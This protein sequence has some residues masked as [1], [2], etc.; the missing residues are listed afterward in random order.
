MNSVHPFLE[1]GSYVPEIDNDLTNLYHY[2][3]DKQ[4]KQKITVADLKDL[5]LEKMNKETIVT[6]FNQMI[7]STKDQFGYT[8]HKKENS[9]YEV[10][11]VY[12]GTELA[13]VRIHI[14]NQN[15]SLDSNTVKE[16]ENTIVGIQSFDVTQKLTLGK[17]YQE[18]TT[19]LK[20]IMQ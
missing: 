15:L 13:Y 8:I 20:S 5:S 9:D 6:L 14:K 12:E 17:E 4:F 1:V 16:I 11:Y 18:L 3:S 19:F 7:D 10:I 2:L